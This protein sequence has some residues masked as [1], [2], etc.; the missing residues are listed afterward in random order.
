[1]GSEKRAGRRD[2]RRVLGAERERSGAGIGQ[3][4]PRSEFAATP[5]TTAMRASRPRPRLRRVRSTSAR[6]IAYC[7]SGKIRASSLLGRRQLSDRVEQCAVSARRRR[8]RPG[9]PRNGKLVGAGWPGP[10]RDRARRRP[11]SRARAG[12][13][14]CRRPRPPRR[15]ASAEH[16]R[17]P[18]SPGRRQHRVPA[19]RR[20]DEEGRLERPSARDTARRRDP[21][22]GRPPP[23]EADGPGVALARRLRQQRADQPRACVDA[24]KLDVVER[25]LRPHA[26]ILRPPASRLEMTPRSDLGHDAAGSAHADRPGGDDVRENR[27]RPR[28]TAAAVSSQEVSRPSIK[29]VARLVR[30]SAAAR[31]GITPHDQCVLADSV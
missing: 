12:A 18:A 9:D 29:R 6:T 7:S 10:R 31:D 28:V 16:A 1:M 5:P 19:A 24:D 22:D 25:R 17:L 14:S 21:A 26:S 30:R 11:D 23:A 27:G 15:R 4:R 2:H 8:S 20:R 3:R 13:H